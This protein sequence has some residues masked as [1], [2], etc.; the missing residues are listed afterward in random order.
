MLSLDT[1]YHNQ[2]LVARGVVVFTYAMR[3]LF[4][5]PWGWP[6]LPHGLRVA[7]LV[8]RWFH[9]E[10]RPCLVWTD[11]LCA[12]REPCE[13]S[14]YMRAFHPA[15]LGPNALNG[16]TW[17]VNMFFRLAALRSLLDAAHLSW[18]LVRDPRT[19]V[20]HKLFLGAAVALI[21]SPINWIPSF[22]PILGQLEDLALLGAALNLFLK[23]VPP[24][25]RHEHEA[26]LA[27]R[28][29]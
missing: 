7:R 29:A 25:L 19:P 3:A 8:R 20:R 14:H 15:E 27:L 24:E 26:A 10:A 5:D 16:G 13:Q 12:T 23:R 21:V 2:A 11:S 9:G 17:F 4:I 22:I 28:G 1:G 18:R 6:V